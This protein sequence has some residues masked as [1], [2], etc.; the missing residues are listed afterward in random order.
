MTF[1]QDVDASSHFYLQSC[2]QEL[3]LPRWTSRE[4]Q[5]QQQFISTNVDKEKSLK[6][7]NYK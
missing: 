2:N 4:Q 1:P 5:Q 3:Y 7:Y 6:E